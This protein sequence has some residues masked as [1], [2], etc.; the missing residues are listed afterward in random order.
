MGTSNAYRIKSFVSK[1]YDA[2]LVV[3]YMVSL[4]SF[5]V[6]RHKAKQSVV[7]ENKMRTLSILLFI[8]PIYATEVQ[9][10]ERIQHC[11]A[12]GIKSYN[13]LAFSKSFKFAEFE[14]YLRKFAEQVYQRTDKCPCP[15][16]TDGDDCDP[17]QRHIIYAGSINKS[18]SCNGEMIGCVNQ[19]LAIND[20]NK[21][22]YYLVRRCS[23][24]LNFVL[25]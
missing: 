13:L 21:N 2:I 17:P 11:H 15:L 6:G 14:R 7:I 8:L 25:F 16:S 3:R 19:L 5:T 22:E 10:L 23:S 18:I 20:P 1:V 4:S 24:I 12:Y 9:C